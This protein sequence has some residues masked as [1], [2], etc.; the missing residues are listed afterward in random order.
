MTAIHIAAC[1]D[2]NYL[3]HLAALVGSIRDTRSE[4][5]TVHVLAD[6]VS[7]EG[8]ERITAA[9]SPVRVSWY[10][11]D[12]HEALS[13][14]PLLQ[15]SRATY[16]RLLIPEVLSPDIDRLIYLDIDVIVNADLSAL[17]NVDLAG[18]ACGAVIDPGVD[19]AAFSAKFDL[20]S[21]GEYFNAGILLLDLAKVRTEGSFR[22]ALD[23]LLA[24][25]DRFD[26]ADQDALNLVLWNQ[27]RAIDPRWN[28]Q[29]KFLYA[30]NSV[31]AAATDRL[32]P[33]FIVHYTES[34]KPWQTREWHPYAWL[35]LRQLKKTRF[36][37]DV[38]RRERLTPA[39]LLKMRCKYLLRRLR[40]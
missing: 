4:P 26:L 29:R 25:R 14:A 31:S 7:A 28:F 32:E 15:I 13:L 20:A 22:R 3:P 10:D 34:T 30:G 12:D 16:L 35:Y 17:W 39:H 36:F 11:I 37:G 2:Q 8:M 19:A 5:T 38:R 18:S 24:D 40:R 27:W 6:R 33:P 21:G 1:V 9:A 23:L